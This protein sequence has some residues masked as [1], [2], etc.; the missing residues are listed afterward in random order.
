MY[1]SDFTKVF[2]QIFRK[3]EWNLRKHRCQRKMCGLGLLGTELLQFFLYAVLPSCSSQPLTQV[4]LK[5]RGYWGNS[6][7][8]VLWGIDLLRIWDTVTQLCINPGVSPW[9]RLQNL[10]QIFSSADEQKRHDQSGEHWDSPL[11]ACC[12][13]L[14]PWFQKQWIRQ[15]RDEAKQTP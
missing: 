7:I 15:L 2:I 11:G 9:R 13:W 12:R 1:S 14:G 3:S 10:A 6:E 4:S 5:L 8:S